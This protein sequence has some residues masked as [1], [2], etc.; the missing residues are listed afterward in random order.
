MAKI[1]SILAEVGNL[2]A[3]MYCREENA[4]LRW[5]ALLLGILACTALICVLNG[6]ISPKD[7]NSMLTVAIM[8]GPTMVVLLD[9]AD[10]Y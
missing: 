9:S 6:H 1:M 3:D 5:V 8:V 10:R 2:L 4:A 7:A